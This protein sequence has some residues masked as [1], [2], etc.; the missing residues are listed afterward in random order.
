MFATPPPTQ[1]GIRLGAPDAPDA[2][3]KKRPISRVGGLSLGCVRR[4]NLDPLKS[5]PQTPSNRKRKRGIPGAPLKSAPQTPL[6]KLSKKKVSH[7]SF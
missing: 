3:R 7:R 2:P 6:V 4:L 5:A 1:R